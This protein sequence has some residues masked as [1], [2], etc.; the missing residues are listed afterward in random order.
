MERVWSWHTVAFMVTALAALCLLVIVG[1]LELAVAAGAV[2]T[3]VGA[4]M[5]QATYT[6]PEGP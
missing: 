6:K 4:V 2:G 3:V 5:R 1:H